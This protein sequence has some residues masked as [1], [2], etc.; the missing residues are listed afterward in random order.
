MKKET[1]TLVLNSQN[2]TNRIGT[3]KNKY[4]YYVNWSSFLPKPENINQKYSVKFTCTTLS[5]ASIPDIF[6]L[7][8]D[9]GGSNCY[10]QSNSKSTFMGLMYP[11]GNNGT[12]YYI[13]SK[14]SD[15]GAVTIEYPNNNMI[16]IGLNSIVNGSA[17]TWATESYIVL[18]FTPI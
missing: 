1:Y 8:I 12:Y 4:Q 17:N 11:I 2:A 16:T 7:N 3:V 14:Y 13:Q 9:F 5:T 15:N 6:S 10:D 18:E